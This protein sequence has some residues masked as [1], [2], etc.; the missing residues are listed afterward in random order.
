MKKLKVLQ[1][2]GAMNRGGAETVVMNLLR[3][4]DRDAFQFDFLVHEQGRCDYDDEIE[5]LGCAI[6]RI[7][8]FK[9]ANAAS[10]RLACRRF[11]A[12][13]SE[14][15]VVHGHIGSCASIYLDEAHR[16]G[17]ATI[18]HSHNVNST[19]FLHRSLYALLVRDLPH[20][21]DAFLGCSLQAGIDR[22]GI[23]VA[24]SPRFNVMRNGIDLAR[25]EN[26]AVTHDEAKRALGYDGVPLVGIV[27]RLVTQKI[28][29]FL[30]DVFAGILQ[31]LPQARLLIVGR[32]DKE[33]ELR[34]KAERLGM[35]ASVDFL[36]VRDDVPEILKALDVFVFPSLREGLGMSLVEAQAASVPCLATDTIARDAFL[37]DYAQALPLAAGAGEWSRHALALL[38]NP[39]IRQDAR[40]T[41][42]AQGYDIKDVAKWMEDYYRRLALRAPRRRF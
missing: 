4:I 10:Y 2:I 14:Y 35:A 27:G 1:V 8:R 13:H 12:E 16:V 15:Q 19:S 28:Q 22:F 33:G 37:T 30:L 18:A 42:R 38:R 20:I 34:E 39:P 17:C 26:D 6:Y 32:G 24:V 7:P 21:A 36:G 40:Q 11:F 25:Y 29:A 31:E 9:V 3:S 41:I 5:S 23:G